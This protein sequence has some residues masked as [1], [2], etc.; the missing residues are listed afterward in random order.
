MYLSHNGPLGSLASCMHAHIHKSI[1]RCMYRP[2]RQ[3]DTPGW[4]SMC[5]VRC[6]LAVGR[7]LREPP[8]ARVLGC[9]R[10]S[11]YSIALDDLH[12]E[13][14]PV[15]KEEK[16]GSTEQSMP[17]FGE[18]RKPRFPRCLACAP[19]ISR[20]S[21]WVDG[22]PCMHRMERECRQ[23]L[24]DGVVHHTESKEKEVENRLRRRTR[25]QAREERGSFAFLLRKD[26]P[27]RGSL[28]DYR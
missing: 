23:V 22:V 12:T 2:D 14:H 18:G 28:S 19:D 24:G 20:C 27:Q 11:D 25:R 4:M 17:I 13:V 6:S 3:R 9:A 5:L 10:R 1:Y 21:S 8:L 7:S 16:A 15:E 26:S